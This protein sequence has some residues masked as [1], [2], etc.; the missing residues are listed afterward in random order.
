MRSKTPTRLCTS[1]SKLENPNREL[2]VLIK[3]C[4]NLKELKDSKLENPNRELKE[5]VFFSPKRR[6][7]KLDS[8]LEN[9]NR[10]L[11]ENL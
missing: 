10:E 8:K 2:K 6:W 7:L 1:D 11:K 4:K 5:K 9:P 3:E